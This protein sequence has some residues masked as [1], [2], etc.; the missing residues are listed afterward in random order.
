M[1]LKAADVALVQ[2]D[3]KNVCDEMR[4]SE[5]PLFP[6]PC[7]WRPSASLCTEKQLA[8]LAAGPG[9]ALCPAL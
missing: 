6:P 3:N 9:S 7:A 8:L 4:S 1:C 5:N 2:H